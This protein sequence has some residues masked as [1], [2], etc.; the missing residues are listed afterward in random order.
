MSDIE[1]T[2]RNDRAIWAVILVMAVSVMA[3]A[4]SHAETNLPVV[5]TDASKLGQQVNKCPSTSQQ[6]TA[7]GDAS[8][9]RNCPNT[10]CTNASADNILRKFSEVSATSYVEVCTVE[11]EDPTPVYGGSCA[12]SAGNWEGM[13][14]VLPVA[15][16]QE[17]K[18][19]ST[20]TV[21]PMEGVA[22]LSVSLAW[23]VPGATQ[24][25][26]SG[27]WSGIKGST[28]SQTIHNLT[29]NATYNLRCIKVTGS[30]TTGTAKVSWIL[31]THNVDG[32][33][34]TNL[35]GF[36][37]YHGVSPT[38]LPTSVQVDDPRATTTTLGALPLGLRYFAMRSYN[39]VGAES[40]VLS[41]VASK[42]ITGD[43]SYVVAFEESR[44]VTVTPGVVPNPPTGLTVE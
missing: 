23:V 2:E 36:R 32:S 24:C 42:D 11:K 35:A 34:I 14:W 43:S 38:T 27:S 44:K 15:V 5:C 40:T 12:T 1:P 29:A 9:V 16:R 33:P 7:A 3:F 31:P 39:T 10:N 26:A 18:N 8:L 4:V 21:T 37:I 22:P 20:F 17:D 28:G 25:E 19:P 30:E 6:F 13:R 41:N